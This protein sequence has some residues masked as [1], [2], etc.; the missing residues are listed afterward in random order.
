[1]VVKYY[2]VKILKRKKIKDV[3]FQII[4]PATL[5]ILVTIYV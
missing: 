5:Y 3:D 2:H 4:V 1:M